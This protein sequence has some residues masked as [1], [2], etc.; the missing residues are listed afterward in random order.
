M[1]DPDF[2]QLYDDAYSE[3]YDD[4]W[5]EGVNYR[6]EICEWLLAEARYQLD[7]YQNLCEDMAI[8]IAQRSRLKPDPAVL[9]DEFITSIGL[10][11]TDYN[12]CDPTPWPYVSQYP[13]RTDTHYEDDCKCYSCTNIRY[14][15]DKRIGI[16]SKADE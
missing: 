8:V 4:G 13:Y 15:H 1:H 14:M 9:D 12:P 2:D 3:G 6:N 10:D 11:P 7:E 16:F 5:D